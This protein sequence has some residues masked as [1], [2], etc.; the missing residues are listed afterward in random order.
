MLRGVGAPAVG[1]YISA[2]NQA[3]VRQLSAIMSA[4]IVGYTAMMQRS[5]SDAMAARDRFREV[6]GDLV[7]RHH[8]TAVQHYGDGTLAIFPSAVEA[9]T[10]ALMIQRS[11]TTEPRVALRIGLHVGDIVRDHEGV[12]GDGVNIAARVQ[13]LAVPGSVLLSERVAEEVKNHEGIPLVHLGEY[14]LK[15]VSQ[16]VGVFAAAHDEIVVPTAR[17]IEADAPAE[18]SVAVLPFVNMSDDPT[19]EFFSD[20]VSEEIINALAQLPGLK[21]T[22]RTSSFAFK[23]KQTDVREIARALDVGHVLEG[24]VRSSGNRVRVTAQLIDAESGFHVFSENWDRE[25]EDVFVIQDELSKAISGHLQTALTGVAA[26]GPP[27]T[28]RPVPD[29]EAYTRY[30]EGRHHWNSWSP[31][32]A[33]RSIELYREAIEIDPTLALAYAGIASSYIFL[34]AVGRLPGT[35]AYQEAQAAATRALSLAP[36]S[37]EA[38][39]ALALAA[40]VYEWNRDR[41]DRHF[42]RALALGPGSATVHHYRGTCHSILRR[43]SLAIAALQTARDLDPL[44]PAINNELARTLLTAG[45]AEEALVQIERTLEL[46]PSFRSALEIKAM[47]HWVQNDITSAIDSIRA[48]ASHS[49]SPYAGAAILGYLLA[50]SGDVDGAQEQHRLLEERERVEPGISLVLDFALS[51][52]GMRQHELAL[53]S[54]EKA[55]DSRAPGVIFAWSIPLWDELADHPRFKALGERI[56]LWS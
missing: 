23:G 42:E 29:P 11:M 28:P 14:R 3:A 46:A 20:G 4:D 41:A 30:L 39:L 32:G 25:L 26:P 21:V 17:D 50:R 27:V 35:V 34:G 7:P 8:G 10:C 36:D 6:L 19:R 1:P 13:A 54:L 31:E 12:Y 45:Q 56:G 43:H 48:Y 15:N 44:N 9:T 40:L 52:L 55:V 33:L 2:M 22:S 38:E 18:R 51:H 53:N 16:V 24:S 37:S 47:I 5:E 49:P